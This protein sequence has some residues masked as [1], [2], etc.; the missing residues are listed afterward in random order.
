MK[1]TM[2]LRMMKKVRHV[3]DNKAEALYIVQQYWEGELGDECSG[4]WLDLPVVDE[5]GR[6]IS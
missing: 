1:P 4:D 2:Q 5:M 3:S 6:Q